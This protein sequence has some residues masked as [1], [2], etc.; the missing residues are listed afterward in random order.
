MSLLR[1]AIFR[2]YAGPLTVLAA[3]AL[4]C[5]PK[6]QPATSGPAPSAPAPSAGTA[7]ILS[8]GLSDADSLRVDKIG[9]RDG[10]LR[11][12]GLLDLAF[13]ADVQGPIDA[14]FVTTVNEKGEPTNTFRAYTLVGNQEPPE[15][16]RGVVER[17]S[18]ALALG[19]EEGGRLINQ[20]SGALGT[21]SPDRHSLKLYVANAGNLREGTRLV[22]FAT[23]PGGA[24]VRSQ[25]FTY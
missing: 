10:A 5:G 24:V 18:S 22:L 13:R 21:L 1:S 19:V 16:L 2:G 11:P 17:G 9:L 6:V 3:L 15:E 23:A 14:L 4:A 7:N 25:P 8:F 20:E 12:D